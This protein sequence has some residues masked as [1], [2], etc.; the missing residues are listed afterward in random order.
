ML[1]KRETGGWVGM[2]DTSKLEKENKHI[3]LLVVTCCRGHCC[4]TV[5]Q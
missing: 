3:E 1:L 5:L 4:L 2:L